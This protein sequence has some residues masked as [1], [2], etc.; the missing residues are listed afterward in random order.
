MSSFDALSE[1]Q[2][3]RSLL[4][5]WV[6]ARKK[7]FEIHS[8]PVNQRPSHALTYLAEMLLGIFISISRNLAS[9]DEEM[10]GIVGH[11]FQSSNAE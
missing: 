3:G 8:W 6:Q 9:R 4:R 5:G 7:H 1:G 11:S 10:V 2:P